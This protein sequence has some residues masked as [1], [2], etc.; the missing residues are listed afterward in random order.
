MLNQDGR[1]EMLAH[2]ISWSLHAGQPIPDGMLVMHTCDNPGCVNPAHLTLGTDADNM[3]DK[4]TKGRQ[5]TYGLARENKMKTHCPKGHPLSGDNLRV[6][7]DGRRHCRQCRNA[8]CLARYYAKK[9][10]A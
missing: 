10:V 2:R 5:G 4:V 6:A 1:Y 9:S 3:R 8:E 7:K